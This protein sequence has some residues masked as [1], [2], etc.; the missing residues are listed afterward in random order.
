MFISVKSGPAQSP[1]KASFSRTATGAVLWFTP[2]MTILSANIGMHS[3]QQI[4][5]TPEGKKNCA[6]PDNSHDCRPPAPPA[7]GEPLM[8][9][10]RVNEPGDQGPGFLG[11][12]LPVRPPGL[13][14][15][16]GTSDDPHGHQ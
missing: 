9:N 16:D 12:P 3:P 13:F 10:S 15:P 7:H 1:E 5:H 8:Q 11:I 6:K 14:S 4:S 2:M